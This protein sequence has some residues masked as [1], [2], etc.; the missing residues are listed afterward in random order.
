MFP[1][2]GWK[3]LPL[4]G[5]S[6]RHIPYYQLKAPCCKLF[7]YDHGISVQ[8]FSQ[9][10]VG[11]SPVHSFEAWPVWCGLEEISTLEIEKWPGRSLWVQMRSHNTSEIERR[12]KERTNLFL[13]KTKISGFNCMRTRFQKLAAFA[14][15]PKCNGR[16]AFFNEFLIQLLCGHPQIYSKGNLQYLSQYI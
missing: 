12:K 14:V 8:S 7:D 3:F 16:T 15:P 4:R 2:A 13:L 1:Y 9:V 5:W 6:E 11:E 10:V